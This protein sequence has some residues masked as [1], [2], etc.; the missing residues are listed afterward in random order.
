MI[1]V[2]RDRIVK[3]DWMTVNCVELRFQVTLDNFLKTGYRPER[4]GQFIVLNHCGFRGNGDNYTGDLTFFV[5]CD[6]KP[7]PGDLVTIFSP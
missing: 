3:G 5:R 7:P 1:V 4:V 2:R 6:V